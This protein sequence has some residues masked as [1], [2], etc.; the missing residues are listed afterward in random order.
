MFILLL[1]NAD[2]CHFRFTKRTGL[3][4]LLTTCLSTKAI[5]HFEVKAV[6]ISHDNFYKLACVLEDNNKL[7]KRVSITKQ[8]Q[9]SE[10]LFEC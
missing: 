1:Q 2:F 8:A 7:R 4:L 9:R 10:R 3:Q 6:N 5:L